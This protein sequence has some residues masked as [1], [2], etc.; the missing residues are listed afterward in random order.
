MNKQEVIDHALTFKY[1]GMLP[2]ELGLLYDISIG[3]QSALELGS[4]VGM[5]SYVIASVAEH[6]VCVDVWSDNQDHLDHDPRQKEVYALYIDEL[7]NMFDAF[8]TN[9]AKE[10]CLG[11]ITPIRLNTQDAV[12]LFPDKRF[13]MILI[14]ADHSY[15]G[16]KRDYAAYKNKL[17]DGG[18]LVFHDFNDSMWDGIA[19]ACN[20][21]V[22]KGEIK[23]IK[24][25]ERLAVFTRL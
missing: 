23:M 2:S 7:P 24:L 3:K 19:Q 25:I 14:D 22:N 13:D 5:S 6:L 15:E 4:M 12:Y 16:V 20:E 8:N 10:I 11:K 21:A 1:G 17:K 9:C 18:I